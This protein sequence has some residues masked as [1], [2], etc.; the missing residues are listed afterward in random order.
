MSDATPAAP[1]GSEATGHGPAAPESSARGRGGRFAAG[2]LLRAA[3]PKQWLKNLL[4]F[5]AP[6][7]AGLLAE[8]RALAWSAAAFALFCAA[9]SGTY[10]LNDVRDATRD[11]MHEH[12][13]TRPVAAGELSPALAAGVGTAL[14]VAAPA[15]VVP[16]GNRALLAVLVGYLVLTTAYT[17]VLKRVTVVDLVA[18]A[19]CHVLRAVA[20]GAAIGVPLTRWFL[21]VVSLGALLVVTGK[22]EAELRTPGAAT[23]REA[24]GRYSLSYLTQV[25]TMAS[26][27]MIVTYC[28]WAL[29]SPAGTPYPVIHGI[30]IVPFILVVL[31]YHLLVDRGV[32]EEP[33]EIALRDRPLQLCA[34]ALIALIGLGV[35]LE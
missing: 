29:E 4:V 31:R 7:T 15:A 32:G 23:T 6:G 11:R 26:A 21:I 13:R 12:K 14:L 16:A 1:R 17:L 5:A 20:G 10:L 34:V 28:L 19:G 24:L 3:R 9:S 8:P 27:A 2:A 22:R 18:V 25:R 35:Y 33:E 30:S